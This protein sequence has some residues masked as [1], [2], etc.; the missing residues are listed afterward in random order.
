MKILICGYRH[1]D[2]YG[3]VLNIV[4]RLIKRYGN[5]ITIIEGDW[6]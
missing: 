1:W 6:S 4:K 2:D 3:S 5:D